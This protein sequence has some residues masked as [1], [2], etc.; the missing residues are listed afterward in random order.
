MAR[1]GSAPSW[2]SPDVLLPEIS[3]LLLPK[4]LGSDKLAH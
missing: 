3:N 1:C 2:L 4:G